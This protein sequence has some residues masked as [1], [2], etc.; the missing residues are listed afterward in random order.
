MKT[1]LLLFDSLNRRFLPPYGC[2]EVKAPGFERLGEWCTVFDN[3][4]V[5]SMPCIPARRDLHT[6]RCHF[7]HREWGPLEP[8]DKSVFSIL[9]ENGIYSHLITDHYNYWEE[10]GGGY[11]TKYNS[12]EFVRGQEGDRWKGNAAG[13][14]IPPVLKELKS[15]SGKG[16][17]GSW[18]AN[19][20]NREELNPEDPDTYPQAKVFSLAE[21]FLEKNADADNWVLQVESFS[22][23]EPFLVPDRFRKEYED[24]YEGPVYDW[25]RGKLEDFEDSRVVEHM[26][27]LY[28]ASVSMSDYYLSR[29]LDTMDRLD[30]WKDTMLIVGAD[31]GILLG[32][33]QYWSKNV[34]PYY[35][36]IANTPLFIHDPRSPHPGERRKSIVQMIDWAPTLLDCYGIPAPDEMKGHSLKS[37]IEDDRPVRDAAIF[38]VFSGHVN[39]VDQEHIYMRAAVPERADDIF[40]YTVLPLHMFTPFREE[41]LRKMTFVPPF[42]FTRG[43]G[44]LKIPS[45]DLYHVARFGNLLFDKIHDP[46]Q[47]NPIAD[48]DQ[49]EYLCRKLVA[50]M[51]EFDAPREQYYRLG[52]EAYLP[53]N[54]AEASQIF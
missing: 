22:P 25:P 32:E 16:L 47:Q 18:V 14:E 6:G 43:C 12:F 2:K 51:Q 40:N 4:Y 11:H 44:L 8:Y 15:H 23:H 3:S 30:M 17:S 21:E 33:H 54:C 34:M 53:E 38:G 13:P 45:K 31:H 42:S 5:A 48:Q 37:V 29:L 9:K 28:K 49:E 39:L 26:R 20:V 35:N 41:E 1:I 27:T 36:E 10:G 50:K 52:L 7:L 19:W 46:K 24:E